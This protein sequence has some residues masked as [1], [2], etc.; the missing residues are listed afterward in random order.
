MLD[1]RKYCSCPPKLVFTPHFLRFVVE[2][3]TSVFLTCLKSVFWGKQ[4]H[5]LC[6]NFL[7]KSYRSLILCSYYYCYKVEVKYHL[8]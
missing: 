8:P 7:C 1:F 6:I 2:V 3:K 4:G 5:Y